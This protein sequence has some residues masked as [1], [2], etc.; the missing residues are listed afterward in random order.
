MKTAKVEEMAQ[1]FPHILTLSKLKTIIHFSNFLWGLL[2]P[3]L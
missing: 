2:S 3:L 1:V